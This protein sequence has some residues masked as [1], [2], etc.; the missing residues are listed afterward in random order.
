MLEHL[1]PGNQAM[2]GQFVTE[3]D[4]VQEEECLPTIWIHNK[5]IHLIAIP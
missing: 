5:G 3:A 2:L 4:Q 1:E